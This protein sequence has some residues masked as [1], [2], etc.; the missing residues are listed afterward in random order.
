MGARE[1]LATVEEAGLTIA[2]DGGNLVVRPAAKLTDPLRQALKAAKPE[3]LALL[4]PAPGWTEADCQRFT[5]R[6][7]RLLRWGWPAP[8]AESLAERLTL[9]DREGDD[10]K[11][12]AE[13]AAYRPGR[14]GKHRNARLG[15][16]DVGRDLATLL[17]RCPGFKP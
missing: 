1:L 11:S 6:R 4:Q 15:T 12:C 3:L 16:S 10:R 8:A 17:Q 13:C 2:A 14:C 5:A 7:D 9:R